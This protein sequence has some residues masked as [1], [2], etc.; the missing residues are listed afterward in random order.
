LDKPFEK[1]IIEK[2]R[3]D[4]FEFDYLTFVNSQ[5]EMEIP[6]NCTVKYLPKNFTLDNNYVK[7]NFV[8]EV[9]N[10]KITLTIQLQQKKLLLDKSDFEPWNKTIKQLKNNYTDTLI[11]LEK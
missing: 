1:L 2:D 9:K 4:K 11:L 3:V 7:A 8:Y 10:N 6:K 5:Y